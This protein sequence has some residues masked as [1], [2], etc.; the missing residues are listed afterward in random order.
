MVMVVLIKLLIQYCCSR[1]I[2]EVLKELSYTQS[3]CQCT[4]NK[5]T[6]TYTIGSRAGIRDEALVSIPHT[7]IASAVINAGCT[8]T[9]C[10]TAALFL[11]A[12]FMFCIDLIS[13]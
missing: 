10:W 2:D 5:H 6:N 4:D 8:H 3:N 11:E 9:V 12:V 7:L 13:C 1:S